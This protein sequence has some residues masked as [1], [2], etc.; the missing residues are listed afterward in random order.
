MVF[1]QITRIVCLVL[2]G[3]T[4]ILALVTLFLRKKRR[5]K[6]ALISERMALVCAITATIPAA[7]MLYQEGA[8]Y[9]GG[10]L[11]E[12]ASMTNRALSYPGFVGAMMAP[13]ALWLPQ[14][15]RYAIVVI[16][17]LSVWMVYNWPL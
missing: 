10:N 1:F 4:L 9:F 15:R 3:A 17:F 13:L 16:P 7:V 2:F 8:V 11:F 5:K 12:R 14:V 6:F